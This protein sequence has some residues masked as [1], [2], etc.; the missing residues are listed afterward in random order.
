[1]SSCTLFTEI[2]PWTIVLEALSMLNLSTDFP[3]TFQRQDISLERSIEL[4]A[5][6]EPFYKPCKAKQFLEYTDEK[7]WITILRQICRPHGI[8][9]SSKE[10][11]RQNKKAIIYTI[12]KAEVD[13]IEP[14][15][16]TFS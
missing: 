14:V 9:V 4:A 3:L 8:S 6:L 13:I 11:T 5:L 1:M 16:I 15:C 7:R 2:P 12:T 10:T